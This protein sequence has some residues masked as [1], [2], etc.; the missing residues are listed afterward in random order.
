MIAVAM[1]ATRRK[2]EKSRTP[3][4]PGYT[5]EQQ[6]E[7]DARQKRMDDQEKL[8]EDRYSKVANDEEKLLDVYNTHA[9]MSPPEY[10]IF[11]V[12]KDQKSNKKSV[13]YYL[14]NLDNTDIYGS[15]FEDA[16]NKVKLNIESPDS[17]LQKLNSENFPGSSKL[18]LSSYNKGISR[19]MAWELDGSPTIEKLPNIGKEYKAW[20]IYLSNAPPST[21]SNMRMYM[22]GK[23]KGGKTK[24]NNKK[25]KTNK[26]KNS[27]KK[28]SKRKK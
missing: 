2:G 7:I 8:L 13:P 3:W 9:L 14:R 11:V 6:A 21:F 5:P 19:R 28:T 26:R 16:T 20:T 23:V 18:R 24:K 4:H 17:S 15:S 25:R 27:K 22:Q 12:I 10:P 1:N